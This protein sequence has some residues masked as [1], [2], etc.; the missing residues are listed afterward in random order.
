MALAKTMEVER[1]LRAGP[2]QV[3][4]GWFTIGRVYGVMEL[5]RLG[6]ADFN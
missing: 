2:W 4:S 3:G 6:A 5:G 1:M